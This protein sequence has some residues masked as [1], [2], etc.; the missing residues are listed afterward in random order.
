MPTPVRAW[1]APSSSGSGDPFQAAVFAAFGSGSASSGLN[2]G[3]GSNVG[4]SMVVALGSGAVR[5][6]SSG[7]HG[8]C[9]AEKVLPPETAEAFCG[10]ADDL[11][12]VQKIFHAQIMASGMDGVT[13]DL[14]TPPSPPQG[15]RPFCGDQHDR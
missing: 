11:R 13:V 15:A 3:P 2:G 4:R 12:E 7:Q 10:H 9:V 8:Y 5:G 6:E 1:P 14:V